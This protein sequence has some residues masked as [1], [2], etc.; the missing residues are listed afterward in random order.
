[1][2]MRAAGRVEEKARVWFLNA[3]EN[4]GPEVDLR[5]AMEDMVEV[6]KPEENAAEGKETKKDEVL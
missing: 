3:F 5:I 4:E 6:L 1:M 2:I